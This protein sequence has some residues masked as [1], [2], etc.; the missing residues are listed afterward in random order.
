MRKESKLVHQNTIEDSDR[1]NNKSTYLTTRGE[2]RSIERKAG[3]RSESEDPKRQYERIKKHVKYQIG[4]DKRIL[5]E[6]LEDV[7]YEMDLGKYDEI[8]YN[9][10]NL[11]LAQMGMEINLYQAST[12]KARIKRSREYTFQVFASWVLKNAKFFS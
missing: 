10:A 8:D 4:K 6:R 2:R 3:D 1:R 7:M 9:M 5:Q 11:L 12:L